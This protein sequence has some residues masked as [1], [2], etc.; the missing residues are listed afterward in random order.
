MRLISL[1][2][3]LFLLSSCKHETQTNFLQ[4]SSISLAQPRVIANKTFIDSFVT[5]K[6]GLKVE[7][8]DI[9]FTSNGDEPSLISQKYSQPIQ[10][11]KPGVYKFKAFHRDWKPSESTAITLLKKGLSANSILWHTNASEKYKGQGT[12]TVINQT[13]ASLNFT[14]REWVGFDTTAIATIQF[15]K[16]VFIKSLTVSYLSDP[17]SWI[18]P[19]ENIEIFV[20]NDKKVN[21]VTPLKGFVDKNNETISIPIEAEIKS[22]KIEVKNLQSIPEWHEGKGQK[23]WLFIDEL[24]FN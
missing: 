21:P 12:I 13:K 4:K 7:D 6:A 11:S 2:F 17:A 5:I 8:V 23:A 18:F 15:N 10:A 16:K 24:I 19:P 9:Y 20:D 1:C 14:D 22:L 3:M